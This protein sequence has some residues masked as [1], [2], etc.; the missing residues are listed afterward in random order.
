MGLSGAAVLAVDGGGSKTDAVLFGLDG[1]VL[2]RARHGS[3]SPQVLGLHAAMAVVDAAVGEVLGQVPGAEV[4]RAHAYLSGLD[5]PEEVTAFR[6]VAA[7]AAWAPNDDAALQIDNDMFALLRAGTAEPDAVAVVC[8]TG[9]NAIGVRRDGAT[10]RFPAFGAI[11]G[12]WG[13]GWQLGERAMWH[14]ARA[15]DG[16]GPA[17]SLTER[18]PLEF[19]LESVDAVIRALHFDRLPSAALSR[20]CPTVF[21]AATAGDEIAGRL[22]DRQA[23]EIVILAVTT[24]RRLDLLHAEVPVVLGGGLIASGDERL[25]GGIRS[26]IAAAS[27]AARPIEVSAPPVVGAALLAA[28]GAG[29]G[30]SAIERL[31]AGLAG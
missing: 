19:G 10:V 5:L 23:E 8:G 27:P 13:G 31:R 21:A 17:T 30:P 15:G 16:R 9:I 28:E 22:V 20:L 12:D 29:L 3:G 1:E 6:A 24:L 2:A 18:I 26:G 25:L 11:T 7:G 14:A 4:V